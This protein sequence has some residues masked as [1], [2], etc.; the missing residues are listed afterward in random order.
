M[1]LAVLS[2]ADVTMAAFE[3]EYV[4]GLAATVETVVAAVA[5]GVCTAYGAYKEG[6]W[7]TIKLKKFS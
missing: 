5:Y 3:V 1:V 6:C 4:E 2:L 7:C